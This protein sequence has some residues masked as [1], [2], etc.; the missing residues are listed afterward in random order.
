MAWEYDV[1]THT[2]TRNGET[3]PAEYA[4]AAGYKNDSSQECVSGKGP[5]PRGVYTIGSPHNSSHTGK[6]TLD[7]TP[8][9][10]NFMCGRSAFRIHGA[11]KQHPLDSSEG[12]IIASISVRKSIWA[13][14]DRE[15]KV[16]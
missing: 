5:L 16:K 2:F 1:A 12:C 4:G 13:S 15:L 6:Y 3:H 7:L 9:L 11:S 10:S 8:A 14:G